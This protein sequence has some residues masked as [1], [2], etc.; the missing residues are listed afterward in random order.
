MDNLIVIL[1]VAAI[2][3]AA[4]LY[5]RKEKKRGARCIGCPS[6]GCANCSA[7]CN[8]QPTNPPK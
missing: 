2:V 4:A 5:V 3:L 8:K 7:G 6:G 1:V